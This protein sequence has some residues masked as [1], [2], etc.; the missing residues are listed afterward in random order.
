[1]ASMIKLFGAICFILCR[2]FLL[3]GAQGEFSKSFNN[4]TDHESS[5]TSG[6]DNKNDAPQEFT[7]MLNNLEKVTLIKFKHIKRSLAN[8][9][10][11]IWSAV[12]DRSS[13]HLIDHIL[14]ENV[15]SQIGAFSL[16]QNKFMNAAIVLFSDLGLLNGYIGD[17]YVIKNLPW[18]L[19]GEIHDVEGPYVTVRED[20]FVDIDDFPLFKKANKHDK[21]YLAEEIL[22]QTK[23]LNKLNR[24]QHIYPEL[25]VVIDND[26]Y[27]HYSASLVPRLSGFAS[28]VY[29]VLTQIHAADMLFQDLSDPVIQLNIAAIVIE[30]EPHMIVKEHEINR[31]FLDDRYLRYDFPDSDILYHI[32]NHF[33]T[34]NDIFSP[35]SFDILIIM[36]R[37]R[38]YTKDESTEGVAFSTLSSVIEFRNEPCPAV[39]FAILIQIENDN[40]IVKTIAN[41]IGQLMISKDLSTSHKKSL[42]LNTNHNSPCELHIVDNMNLICRECFH[43]IWSKYFTSR[44]HYFSK[45]SQVCTFINTPRSLYPPGPKVML[46]KKEQCQCLG[47]EDANDGYVASCRN[48][49]E[50]SDSHDERVSLPFDGTPCQKNRVCWNN[51]CVF[52]PT[53]EHAV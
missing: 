4:A 7:I 41:K 31:R 48:R 39:P 5:Q 20:N 1:M 29:H 10:L 49:I 19:R 35:D 25:L 37:H 38:L 17:K 45:S 30:V 18:N 50:C 52:V 15:M 3:N 13:R 43:G 36:T 6:R 44:I 27:K 53:P 42:I 46:S 8:H 11:P 14:L 12:K 40:D 21:E 34:Y 47:Y 9:H 2:L 33:H 16:Y 28:V 26:L 51:E 22:G 24:V 32:Q 23:N